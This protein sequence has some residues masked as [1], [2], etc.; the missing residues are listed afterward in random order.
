MKSIYPFLAFAA[1]KIRPMNPMEMDVERRANH[2]LVKSGVSCQEECLFK[3]LK[4]HWCFETVSP[5][6]TT[7]W[8]W[9]QSAASNNWQL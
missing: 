1:A 8:E 2:P 4:N 3:D 5:V 7:G 9:S 6:L